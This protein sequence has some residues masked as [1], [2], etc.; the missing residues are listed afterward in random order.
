MGVDIGCGISA[1]NTNLKLTDKLDKRMWLEW[2]NKIQRE[3][4]LGFNSHKKPQDIGELNKKLKSNE[5]ERLK[6]K[7]KLQ[8]GTLG[9]GNHFIEA[10]KDETNNIWIMVHSG[11]RHIGL[12]IANHY[13][14]IAKEMNEKS[15]EQTPD[16]LWFLREDS[17]EG[18]NYHHDMSW[19]ISYALENRWR[20]LQ[21]A[22]DT[23]TEIINGKRVDVRKSGINIHHNFA[24]KETHFGKEVIVH[25]K[26]ATQAFYEQ[27]GIIP[28]SMGTNSYIVK[29]L[30]NPESYMSCSHGAGRVMSRKQA[31][32]TIVQQE[33]KKALENTHTPMSMRFIDEAPQ[34]YKPIEEVMDNQKDL[35]NIVHTL[36]PIITIKG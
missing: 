32:R 26:G 6:D 30:G 27:I 9:G 2:K 20:M 8:I 11:S 10:Q 34:A 16:N 4:P 21:T 14:K 7:A 3:I 31:K 28:G 35:V 33:F 18:N 19:A 15:N 24:N 12:R 23:F 13:N 22:V 25:R 29:G 36:K 5:L 17:K 1:Y